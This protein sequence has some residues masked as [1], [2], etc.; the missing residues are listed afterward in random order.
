MNGHLVLFAGLL[1]VVWVVRAYF[2]PGAPCPRCKG[3]KTNKGSTKKRF[4]TCGR[5]GGTGNRQVLGSRT[6]RS[7][8]RH[9]KKKEK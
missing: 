2:W 5:C 3:R 8:I 6:V 7:V 4:G 9:R 1:V